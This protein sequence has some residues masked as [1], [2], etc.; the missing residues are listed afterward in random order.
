MVISTYSVIIQNKATA[1]SFSRHLPLFTQAINNNRIGICKWVESGTTIDTALPELRELTDDKEEWD[2]VI[3]RFEDDAEMAGFQTAAANPFDFL[4]NSDCEP[5]VCE[6]TVPLI[7]LTH[8]L[9]GVPKPETIF[10]P[11][12]VT[13]KVG[14]SCISYKPVDHSKQLLVHRQ[15]SEKYEFNGHLPNSIRIITV[16]TSTNVKV[17]TQSADCTSKF[18]TFFWKRNRYPSNCRFLVYDFNQEGP[19]QRMEEE[20]N[21]WLSTLLISI[22]EI[23]TSTLQAYKLYKLNTKLNQHALHDC[24]QAFADRLT[25]AQSQTENAI[26]EEYSK[27]LSAGTV[28]PQYRVEVPVTVAEETFS[29][30]AISKKKFGLLSTSSRAEAADW[31]QAAETEARKLKNYTTTADRTLNRAALCMKE[32]CMSSAEEAHALDPYV[33]QDL[34]SE[35][36]VLRNAIIGMQGDL[37]DKDETHQTTL[38]KAGENIRNFLLRRIQK[39]PAFVT[40]FFVSILLLLGSVPALIHAYTYN[41]NAFIGIATVAIAQIFLVLMAAICLLVQNKRELNILLQSYAEQYTRAYANVSAGVQM[42]TDYL[43]S[44]ASHTKGCSYLRLS[45]QKQHE[46]QSL[47][48]MQTRHLH[49]IGHT[50]TKVQNWACAFHCP[51]QTVQDNTATVITIDYETP[52]QQNLLYAFEADDTLCIP[53]NNSGDTVFCPFCFAEKLEIVKEEL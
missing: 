13:D 9:G 46:T 12:E 48:K 20:F 35:T 4:V 37:P 10:Q 28:M 22:N 1:E 44:I 31:Q 5:T 42:F 33:E 8:M 52:P 27:L 2:A 18:N 36:N 30:K 6:S 32:R 17:K 23:D 47:N 11:T 41:S 39:K 26:R 24:L 3:V 14:R 43:T 45:R 29:R 16:R 49:M 19:V 40:F 34:Q 15:L 51:V 21:F 38:K 53:I 7:R 25:V 50:L